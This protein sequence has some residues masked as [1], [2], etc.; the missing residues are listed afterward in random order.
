VDVGPLGAWVAGGEASAMEPDDGTFPK[1]KGD[2][3]YC[4]L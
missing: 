2:L 3:E 4:Y 1:T